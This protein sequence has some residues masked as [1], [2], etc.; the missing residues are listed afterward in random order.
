M[1]RRRA[2]ALV[3]AF[4]VGT[5]SL[6]S[7]F[8]NEAGKRFDETTAQ[9]SYRVRN[10][11]DGGAELA[12][13]ALL[14]AARTALA[15]TWGTRPGATPVLAVGMS[16]FWHSLLGV[17]ERFRPLT[18]IYTWADARCRADAAALRKKFD[19]REIHARTGCML[20]TSFL[21]AK[22]CWL[23]RTEPKLFRAVRWW[24]SPVEWLQR[25]LLGMQPH[26]GLSMAS[27]TGLFN[28]SLGC[29]DEAM[30]DICRVSERKLGS[31]SEEPVSGLERGR[32]G[33][34]RGLPW[35]PAIGDGAASNLGSGA[36]RPG[37]AAINVGTS[38][39]LRVMKSGG[40]ERAAFGLFSYR[41]DET[42]HLV[43][44]AVSNAGNLRAWAM[45]E[46]RIEEREVER[47]LARRP[48]PEHGLTVEP[49]WSPERAPDWEEDKR[50]AIRGI[51]YRTS[52][53]DI[54]QALTEASY[55]RLARIAELVEARGAQQFVISGGLQRS[56]SSLRRLANILNQPLHPSLEMEAS[57][58]GAAIYALGRLG[59]HEPGARLGRPILPQPEVAERYAAIRRELD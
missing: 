9:I 39:A 31:I 13:A 55:F 59:R 56:P 33:E 44:G 52:A 30:L 28:S 20:R 29:W 19:E 6:R 36:T 32:A 53:L 54:L 35:F 24:L 11:G 58:R 23:R 37:L 3:L 45:R 7:A 16:G 50:G 49:F 38:A 15:K 18:P 27:A 46:L 51:T 25:E 14:K 41:V 1:K 2:E 4:D 21:P 5:S 48:A 26:C 43:G 42:R 34:W 10:P 40:G 8:F 47:A 17:D 12:P 22:L 57:L